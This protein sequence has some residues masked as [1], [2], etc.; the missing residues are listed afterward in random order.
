LTNNFISAMLS[1]WVQPEHKA[2][3]PKALITILLKI[4]RERQGKLLTIYS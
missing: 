1:I 2:E 3:H 4:N